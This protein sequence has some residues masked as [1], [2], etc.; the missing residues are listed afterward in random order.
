MCPT[1]R[2][3][4]G[5]KISFQILSE[6]QKLLPYQ[7]ET[8][9]KSP[10]SY[11]TVCK[12]QNPICQLSH[13]PQHTAVFHRSNFPW[14]QH[15]QTRESCSRWSAESDLVAAFAT[16]LQKVAEQLQLANPHHKIW[17][18]SELSSSYFCRRIQAASLRVKL[19]SAILL[20][21]STAQ[22][23]AEPDKG[24]PSSAS[25]H[26]AGAKSHLCYTYQQLPTNRMISWLVIPGVYREKEALKKEILWVRKRWN[27]LH[28]CSHYSKPSQNGVIHTICQTITALIII[29]RLAILC[30]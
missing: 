30:K 3:K 6:K 21:L 8:N 29:F 11:C 26:S 24:S 1:L 4:A 14:A 28:N 9:E 19:C 12:H 2:H 10:N 20:S 16:N 7:V 17:K 23:L 15:Q 25:D 5:P 18:A 13:N 27:F 22:S